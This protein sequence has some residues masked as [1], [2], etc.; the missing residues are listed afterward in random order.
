MIFVHLNVLTSWNSFLLNTFM[1]LCHSMGVPY[2]LISRWKQ[3]L[4]LSETHS[5]ISLWSCL[6][7]SLGTCKPYG[8]ALNNKTVILLRSLHYLIV[9]FHCIAMKAILNVL[10][11]NLLFSLQS[12]R[13]C[14]IIAWGTNKTS[15]SRFSTP[16]IILPIQG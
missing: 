13:R 1:R 6:V 4:F 7:H 15:S 12:T 5:K 2:P 9:V 10:L 8:S 3:A 16:E 11:L 14:R